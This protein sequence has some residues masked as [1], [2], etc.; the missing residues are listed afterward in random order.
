MFGR[1]T[2]RLGPHSSCFCTVRFSSFVTVLSQEIA[3]K[4]VSEMTN[5]VSSGM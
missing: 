1:A 3:G 5:V 4:N 2:I